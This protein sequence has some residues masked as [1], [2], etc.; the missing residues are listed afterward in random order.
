MDR[1]LCGLLELLL[2]LG[3]GSLVAQVLVF[4]VRAMT[5]GSQ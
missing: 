4:L 3:V 5:R 1:Q 2:L